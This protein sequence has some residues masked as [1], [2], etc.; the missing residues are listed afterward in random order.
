[1]KVDFAELQ[2]RKLFLVHEEEFPLV[3][4]QDLGAMILP[5]PTPD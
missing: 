4:V 3:F 5:S 1:M 2:V